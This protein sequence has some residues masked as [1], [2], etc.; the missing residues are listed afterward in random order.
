[1]IDGAYRLARWLVVTEIGIWRSLFL[2]VTRRVAGAG[3]GVQSFTYARQVSPILLAFVFVS[4]VELP[5]VHL[6]IPWD[7]VR[8]VVLVLSVWGLLW[9]IG[10][11]ASLRVFPHQV[12]DAELRIRYGARTEVRV[13]WQAVESVRARRGRVDAQQQVHVEPGDDGAVV[14]LPV[15]KQT[16]V[17]VGL[18]D[19][20]VLE[21]PGGPERVTLVQFY[22]DDAPGVVGAVRERLER[23]PAPLPG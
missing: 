11:W 3:P 22:A 5:V 2:L 10:M 16:R 17:E 6:L 9:M 21:L 8:L 14:S 20:A 19:D 4:A 23:R 7:L 18:R 15:M 1:M 13:P 12:D